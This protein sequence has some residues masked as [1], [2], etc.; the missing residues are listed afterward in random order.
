MSA[1]AGAIVPAETAPTATVQPITGTLQVGETLTGN[2]TYSDINGDLEGTSTFKWYRADNSSGLNK[3]AI[4]GATAKTYVLTSADTGK[5]ISFEV[6]PVAATGIALGTAVESASIA[7]PELSDAEVPT[8]NIQP[9][10]KEVDVGGSATLSVTVSGGVS[11]T[12]QWYSN[13]TNSTVGASSIAGATSQ[14]YSVPTAEEGTTYYYCIVTNTDNTK[15][16]EKTATAVSNIVSVTVNSLTDAAAPVIIEQPQSQSVTIGQPVKLLIVATGS[17]TLSYQW[18]SNTEPSTENGV[19]IQSTSGSAISTTGAAI[20]LSTNTPGTTYYYCIVTNTDNTK[21]GTKTATTVS[22]IVSVTVNSLT[23]AAAPVIVEQPQNKTANI[24]ETVQL[25]VKATGSGVLSYQWYSNTIASASSGVLIQDATGATIQVPTN[26][27]G[28]AYYYCIVTNTDNSKTGTKTASIT[29]NLARVTVNAPNPSN[30]STPSSSSSSSSSSTSSANRE[31]NSKAEGSVNGKPVVI[32]KTE[33]TKRGAQTV[34]TVSVDSQTINQK[35]ESEGNNSVVT[36]PVGKADVGVGVLTGDLVKNMENRDAVLEIKTDNVSYTLPAKNINI[37]A[38]AQQIGTT[39]ELKDIKVEI[40]I[41]KV[42]P[43]YVKV[44]EN[45]AKK[46][47]F[48]LAVPPVEFTITCTANNKTIAV[49]KFNEYVARTIAI[50]QGVDPKKIT[51]GVVVDPD[52]TVRHVPTVVFVQDGKYYAKINSLTNSIYTVIY[53]PVEFTDVN[54]IMWV[55]DAAND[56][57]SRMIISGSADNLFDPGKEIT[58]AEFAEIIVKALGLKPY[59][60]KSIF[61]D[62]KEDDLRLGYIMTAYEYGLIAGKENNKF[63]PDD[64]ITREQALAIISK[65]MSIT[66]LSSDM[67]EQEINEILTSYKD[68]GKISSWARESVA[69]CLKL[70]IT[71]GKGN[72]LISPKSNITKAEI[73]VI[74]QKLLKKSNLI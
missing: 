67:D 12:Y 20:Q 58:R 33:T 18:Y 28:T 6:T 39:V 65:A 70:E 35:L 37:D 25:S 24:G 72:G 1:W 40:E 53:H 4:A 7:I 44:I 46:G 42:S 23:D 62:V 57:G 59:S 38:I 27:Q 5:Y 34:V 19:E 3:A 15:T 26:L 64:K 30:P 48:I 73:A 22:D 16:G 71:S 32:G 14:S 54:N 17:G 36:V 74:V 60:G 63:A 21:T 50:P 52:G 69:A 66:G 45:T 47:E 41:S 68:S 11:L 10:D 61:S 56:M 55:K 13:S 43:E 8:I 31:E 2:Y 49:S 9:A 51:T 29:S